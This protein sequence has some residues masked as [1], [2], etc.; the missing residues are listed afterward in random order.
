MALLSNACS[1]V[2]L[3]KSKLLTWPEP[4]CEIRPALLEPFKTFTQLCNKNIF[5]L[6]SSANKSHPQSNLLST[7]TGLGF[8]LYINTNKKTVHVSSVR[9][10]AGIQ[11]PVICFCFKSLAPGECIVS[12]LKLAA[13][14]P[15]L[16]SSP[17]E[18][19]S[20]DGRLSF[21]QTSLPC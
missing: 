6:N 5:H 7:D 12:A 10:G 21:C 11:F 19:L 17:K 3:L 1:P 20:G 9:A 16:P 2:I 18:L 13:C 15:P 4:S 14:S 8:F